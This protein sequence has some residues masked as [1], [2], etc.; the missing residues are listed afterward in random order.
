MASVDTIFAAA[1]AES[2]VSPG[3]SPEPDGEEEDDDDNE[4]DDNQD[5]C[6]EDDDEEDDAD[7]EDSDSSG[8][9]RRVGA[10]KNFQRF[11]EDF[12]CGHCGHLQ[13]G[14]GYTNHC[15]ACLWSK[16]VD[17]NPGDRLAECCGLMRPVE[18]DTKASGYRIFQR[19]EDC[20]HE[21]WNRAQVV[22][23]GRE[24]CVCEQPS[25]ALLSSPPLLPAPLPPSGKRRGGTD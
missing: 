18:V 15:T 23:G 17:I 24:P 10:A 25:S 11:I 7:Q 19:C 4:D 5:E 3:E 13:Q 22:A 16:H 2:C 1:A 12:D 14:N 6:E 20:G 8:D 21:R 9:G